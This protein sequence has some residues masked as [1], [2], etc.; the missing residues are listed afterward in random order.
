M[1][2]DISRIR[3]VFFDVDGTLRDTDDQF[4]KLAAELLRP[5]RGLLPA[6]D[7]QHFARRLV[8]ALESP[9]TALQ[10]LRD[11]LKIDRPL[12][13]LQDWMASLQPANTAVS[14][15]MIPGTA[16]M[17]A[18]LAE[19]Y[20]MAIISARGERSTLGFLK[21]HNL[22]GFFQVVVT[23]QTCRHTK[24]FP[25]PLLYAAKRLGVSPQD[26][27]IVGD[28]T[29]DI[30]AGRKAGAQTVGVLCGFGEQE[31]LA[32]ES[33][34]LILETTPFLV[35]YLFPSGFNC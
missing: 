17:L 25:D 33:A 11:R 5:I 26:C 22:Q 29:V 18:C 30:R 1:A 34:D 8:M 28:T 6:G 15:P 7:A 10:S 14:R 21:E 23:G 32:R 16:E 9:G 19:C 2:L 4:V 13:G 31:E 35:S 24:P 20:P 12:A 27:L 3:A